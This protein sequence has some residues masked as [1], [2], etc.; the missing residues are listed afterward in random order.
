[1]EDVIRTSKNTNRPLVGMATVVDCV[2]EA[3][4]QRKNSTTALTFANN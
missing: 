2:R 4:V 3:F 1:M